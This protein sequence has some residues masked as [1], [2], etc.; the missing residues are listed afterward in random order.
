M[1][2]Y[3]NNKGFSLIELIVSLAVI[4]I[5]GGSIAS[6]LLTGSNSYASVINNTD[7]Q[8]EAQLVM[9]Q[10]S[11]IVI[12]A[13]KAVN[14]KN[15]D[16]KLEVFNEN[17]KYE[18]VFKNSEKKLYYNKFDRKTGTVKFIP[19]SENVLMAENVSFFEADS[20]KVESTN[21]LIVRI[22]FENKSKTYVKEEIIT[23]RNG[24]T[25]KSGD[26]LYKIYP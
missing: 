13:E 1:R 9:N 21:K 14:F 19:E 8:E 5:V 10:I 23:L 16:N 17:E 3:S 25:V 11:D 12:T 15:A 18:I 4:M 2:K 24:Q 6:F 7:L 22:V 20:T 26:D